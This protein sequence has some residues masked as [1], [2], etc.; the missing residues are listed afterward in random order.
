MNLN[1]SY[2]MWHELKQA[3][4]PKNLCCVAELKQ[5]H[6]PCFIV[7]SNTTERCSKKIACLTQVLINI[8]FHVQKGSIFSHSHS[9]C[10]KPISAAPQMEKHCNLRRNKTL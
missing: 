3:L 4:H 5:F 1:L 8:H 2:M 10:R 7:E 9:L 6:L